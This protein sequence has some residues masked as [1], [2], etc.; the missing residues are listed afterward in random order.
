MI[1]LLCK[2]TENSHTTF[3]A[4]AWAPFVQISI[5]LL[6]AVTFTTGPQAGIWR[7]TSEA[8]QG[9]SALPGRK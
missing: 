3:R 7:A 2:D 8:A 4:S 9:S 6:E 1:M 5:Y